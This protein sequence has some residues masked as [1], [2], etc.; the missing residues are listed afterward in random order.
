MCYDIRMRNLVI[1]PQDSSTDFLK[2]IYAKVK[3]KKIINGNSTPK[4]IER[5]IKTSD[6]VMMLGHGCSNGLFSIRLFNDFRKGIVIEPKESA[7]LSGKDNVYIWCNA[8]KFVEANDLHGF[9]SG[10]FISE[11]SE[12]FFCGVN[13]TQEM[14]NESNNTFS[15]I[16][17]KYVHLSKKELYKKVI[18][19]YGELAKTNPVADYNLSRLCIR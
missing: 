17:G 15:E 8:N 9:Y 10:M 4:D 7:I 11:V 2:P 5:L 1:H 6:R 13:A 18:E 16:V 19:E 14:V 3:S 12:A